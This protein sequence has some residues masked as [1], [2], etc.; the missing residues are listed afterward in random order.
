MMLDFLRCSN[1]LEDLFRNI[2]SLVFPRKF[3]EF[4]AGW[5]AIGEAECLIQIDRW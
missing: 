3:H 4:L 2:P 5:L 1:I